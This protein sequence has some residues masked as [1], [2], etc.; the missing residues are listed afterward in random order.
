MLKRNLHNALQKYKKDS[1]A[2]F[3]YNLGVSLVRAGTVVLLL[4]AAFIV[5]VAISDLDKEAADI[6]GE[7]LLIFLII[8]VTL[9]LIGLREERL[10]MKYPRND[11]EISETAIVLS[12][13]ETD[14]LMDEF[15]REYKKQ[16]RNWLEDPPEYDHPRG[17]HGND[18]FRIE[19][20][21]KD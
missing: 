12:E 19:K 7:L 16:H 8:G 10:A 1:G 3:T 17:D 20:K 11:V 9:L 15:D 4:S 2:H 6:L 21:T 13:E 5:Q 18:L 14:D